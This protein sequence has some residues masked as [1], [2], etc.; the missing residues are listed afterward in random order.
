MHLP[1]FKIQFVLKLFVIRLR[2]VGRTNATNNFIS[3]SS[4]ATN[5][6]LAWG[7]EVVQGMARHE[8]GRLQAPGCRPRLR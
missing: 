8:G 2:V 5:E 6:G 7:D 1:V 3:T 4:S